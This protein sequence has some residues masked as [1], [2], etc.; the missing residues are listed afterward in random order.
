MT[1]WQTLIALAVAVIFGTIGMLM[2]HPKGHPAAGF[3]AGA[4]LNVLGLIAVAFWKPDHE[5]LVR[6][7]A[8]RLAVQRDAQAIIDG[9]DAPYRP[10]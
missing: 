3:F 7:E 10:V 9:R 8:E 6:R 2:G 5:A 4:L 1:P